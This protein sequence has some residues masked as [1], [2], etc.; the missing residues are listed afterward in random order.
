M[1]SLTHS[2]ANKPYALHMLF[3]VSWIDPESRLEWDM[4]GCYISYGLT[5]SRGYKV[6]VL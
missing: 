6:A 1:A 5:L 2:N 4:D 3:N